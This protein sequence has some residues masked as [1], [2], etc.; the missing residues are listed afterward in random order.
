[1][2]FECFISGSMPAVVPISKFGFG[3][4]PTWMDEM[5]C[6]GTEVD[7]ALCTFNGWGKEDCAHSED[8][9]MTCGSYKLSFQ[10]KY[11]CLSHYSSKVNSR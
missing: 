1:M 5:Q 4:G 2:L 6:T 3:A 9:G 11:Y 7:I 10:Y 8:I